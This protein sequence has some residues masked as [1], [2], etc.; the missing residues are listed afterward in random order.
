[1]AMHDDMNP[2][3]RCTSQGM[4]GTALTKRIDRVCRF[5]RIER[6]ALVLIFPACGVR[7]TRVPP[8]KQNTK[9][10][11][12]ENRDQGSGVG[13]PLCITEFPFTR[14]LLCGRST[15]PAPKV[16]AICT[17]A[18]QRAAT[19]LMTRSHAT[20]PTNHIATGPGQTLVRLPE[21]P[22]CVARQPGH[23][24]TC[25]PSALLFPTIL[26]MAHPARPIPRRAHPGMPCS[27]FPIMWLL[28]VEDSWEDYCKELQ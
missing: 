7:R 3:S 21:A 27:K 24:S 15:S 1:M 11:V 22:R 12:H 14:I 4:A 5:I 23:G 10:S 17:Q 6:L 9:S 2:F 19:V 16:S 18:R 8:K 25:A 13:K 26:H 20:C 28:A